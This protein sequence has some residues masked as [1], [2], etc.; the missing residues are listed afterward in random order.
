MTAR[1]DVRK[2]YKLFINGTFV[3]S[4]S[5]RSY[6]LWD[7]KNFQGNIARASRKDLRDAVSAARVAQPRW[8]ALAP[9]LRGLMLYRL[10][11]MLEGIPGIPEDEIAR[12]IDRVLWYAGWC[13]KYGALLSSRNPVA[14]PHFNCSTPEP[15]GVVALLAP[16]RPSLLGTLSELL[17][18]L[19]AGN[20][21]IAI[22]SE[23]D[24]RSAVALAEAVA[25]SD[26]PPG[27]VSVL[28]GFHSELAPAIAKHD[29]I[30]AIAFSGADRERWEMLGRE[31]AASIKRLRP[32]RVARDSE[33]FDDTAESLDAIA[34]YSEIK[35]IWH[36]AGF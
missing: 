2:M 7:G 11:E 27:T 6:P 12:A 24:P 26:I 18:I 23:S 3:R 14:G 16:E 19:V 10:A 8:W 28:T 33:Y 31:S 25:L 13:D 36:P 22:A 30:A 9:Q 5:G 21:A 4:E 1:L 29:A 32:F 35:T 20:A 15:M 17:P 34:D